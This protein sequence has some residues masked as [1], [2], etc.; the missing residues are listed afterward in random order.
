MANNDLKAMNSAPSYSDDSNA[1]VNVGEAQIASKKKRKNKTKKGK[2]PNQR[3]R[4]SE[5]DTLNRVNPRT[6][7][8]NRCFG[9]GSEFHLLPNCPG[10]RPQE[11]RRASITMDP[12]DRSAGG[13]TDGNVYQTSINMGVASKSIAHD[14]VVF[15]ILEPQRTWL[16]PSGWRN[17]ILFF[18]QLAG[19]GPAFV[20]PLRAFAMGMD[21]LVMFTRLH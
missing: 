7:Y 5:D 19:P 10:K 2:D 11:A 12:P 15:L 13:S 4:F 14:S 1:K 9:C 6:G 21:G 17:A 20:R 18:D 16:G 8:R 3:P